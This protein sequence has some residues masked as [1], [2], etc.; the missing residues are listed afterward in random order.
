MSKIRQKI[1]YLYGAV[2][3]TEVSEN[4]NL[5]HTNAYMSVTFFD[6]DPR[7]DET[8]A[9]VLPTAGELTLTGSEDGTNYGTFTNGAIDVTTATYDRPNAAG[10][11][12]NVKAAPT[13]AISGNSAAFY[14]V[15]IVKS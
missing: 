11:I 9:I 2:A 13:S 4:M 5:H 15:M 1:Y 12:Q 14:R 8:A 6:K 10:A 7:I 3:D